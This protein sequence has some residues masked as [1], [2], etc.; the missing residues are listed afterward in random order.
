MRA[1]TCHQQPAGE[2]TFHQVKAGAGRRLHELGE[3]HV[4]VAEKRFLQRGIERHFLQEHG[5][6]DA[7]GVP[8]ALHDGAQR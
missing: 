6:L 5:R 1:V 4:E 3:E 2:A 7:P 8:G